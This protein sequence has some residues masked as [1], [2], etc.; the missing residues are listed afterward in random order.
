MYSWKKVKT[1]TYEQKDRLEHVIDQIDAAGDGLA[2]IVGD[3]AGTRGLLKGWRERAA[4]PIEEAEKQHKDTWIDLLCADI[5]RNLFVY[6]AGSMLLDEHKHLVWLPLKLG[7]RVAHKHRKLLDGRIP[8]DH[9]AAG[10]LYSWRHASNWLAKVDPA[11]PGTPE[12]KRAA[13]QARAAAEL[14]QHL[15]ALERHV[16]QSDNSDDFGGWSY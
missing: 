2:S 10:T 5:R 4:I 9:C 14:E 3:P 6:R 13:D 12:E 1:D 16:Q 11:P 8:G 15:Q 7:K